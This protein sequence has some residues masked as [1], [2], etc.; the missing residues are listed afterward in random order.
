M[1]AGARLDSYNTLGLEARCRCL[2][3]V[4]DA[5]QVGDLWSWALDRQ[6][7]VLFLGEGSNVVFADDFFPG[8]VVVNRISGFEVRG[9]ELLAGGGEPLLEVIRRL[10]ERGL[11]GLESLYGIPGTLAGAVVGNAG[12]Y[13][14]EIGDRVEE[15]EVITPTARFW[16]HRDDLAFGYRTSRFKGERDWFLSR[17]RLRMSRAGSDLAAHSEAILRR[18]LQKY[19]AGIKCPGSFFK[20]VLWA[21]LPP[22]VQERIPASFVL[23][24]KIPAGKLLECVGANGSRRGDAAV[25]SWHGNLFVNLGNARAED[26]LDLADELAGRVVDVFGI[27][28]EPEVIIVGGVRWPRLQGGNPRGL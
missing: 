17:C 5:G 23:H 21:D 27:H 10:N 7:P 6:L 22:E 9:E 4:T 19:P 2:A 28:L 14:Q 11:A 16:C 15:V 8:L 3:D 12:A 13:G 25:A 18:R 1:L 24:G 26:L 20:N